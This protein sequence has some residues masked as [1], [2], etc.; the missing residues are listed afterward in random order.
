MPSFRIL[1]EWDYPSIV[2]STTAK[3]SMGATSRGEYADAT[4]TPAIVP[5]TTP[6]LTVEDTQPAKPASV[7]GAEWVWEND[8][9]VLKSATETPF[10]ATPDGGLTPQGKV[11]KDEADKDK[12]EDTPFTQ[13]VEYEYTKDFTKRRAKFFDSKTGKFTYG[14]WEDSPKTKEDFDIEQARIAEEETKLNEKRD[15]FS[16]IEATMR[17][18]GFTEEELKELT[19]YIT[20]GLINPKLGSNQ[21]LLQLRQLQSYKDRFAGNELRRAKGLNALSEAAYLQQEKDYSQTLALY[22]QD[23]FIS[24]KQ[25]ADLVG[26]D[27]SNTELGKRV[28][29]AVNRLQ[30]ADPSVLKQLRAYYPNISDQD[31]VGYFLNPDQILPE[32][33]AKTTTAEI[34]AT[35]QQYGLGIGL[36]RATELQKYGVD[37]ERARAGYQ[38][39]ARV[40]PRSQELADIYKAAGIDYSQNVAEQEEFKGLASA[41]RARER[42][43]ELEIAAFSGGAGLGRGAL[44]SQAGGQF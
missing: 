25:F 34:G 27:I 1:E 4:T 36:D 23:K 39:I 40:L 20:A 2:N 5:A 26:N 35:A 21:L 17:S 28:S 13:F 18:Y 16:Q 14:E 6:E 7:A 41:R 15:A 19:D 3:V 10:V 38:N 12:G 29:T 32:L 33:E 11:V 44:G 9:W 30:N 8:K 42:L 43:R 37:L 31:I 22:G 24:R